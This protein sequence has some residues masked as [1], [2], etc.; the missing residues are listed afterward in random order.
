MNSF[1]SY[2]DKVFCINLDRR[3]DRWDQCLLNFEKYGIHAERFSGHDNVV[4]DGRKS[5]NAGCTA[6]HRG[7][8][9][10]I[11][12]NQWNRVLVLEDDFICVH[13]PEEFHNLW[14]TMI[15][16]VPEN[17]DLLY[18]GGHYSCP[19]KRRISPH[20]I[21]FNRMFTTSSYGIRGN[22]AK[23]M[24][25]NIYGDQSIDSLFSSFAE[26]MNAYIFQP[27]LMVQA[28]SFSDIQEME[29]NHTFCMLDRNHENMV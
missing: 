23:L 7:V 10:I 8:L 29:V 27:R 25:P 24:A 14:D 1:M 22:V 11:A 19:P 5:G 21:Q 3:K 6:S 13:Q 16:E 26:N 9:E 28:P 18:L 4:V 15:R 2:W 20:V 17:W 12:H